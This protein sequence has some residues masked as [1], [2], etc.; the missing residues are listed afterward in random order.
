MGID[1]YRE[2]IISPYRL[3]YRIERKMVFVVGLFDSRRDLD[4]ILIDRFITPE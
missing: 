2:R 3:I 4:E 1:R